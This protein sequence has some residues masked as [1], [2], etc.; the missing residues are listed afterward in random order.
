M[1][2]SPATTGPVTRAIAAMRNDPD[3]PRRSVLAGA[4]AALTGVIVGAPVFRALGED[5]S[6]V[7]EC[8]LED[9]SD[10]GM[11]LIV[12]PDG[13]VW[14]TVP[15]FDGSDRADARDA[16]WIK[17]ENRPRLMRAVYRAVESGFQP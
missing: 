9:A 10:L 14:R 7:A 17:L 2:I 5:L 11:R 15:I 12:G 16:H 3:P 13:A 4:A 8:W 1:A 6:F